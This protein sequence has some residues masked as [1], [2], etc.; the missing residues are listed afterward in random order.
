MQ[1]ITIRGIKLDVEKEIRKIAR[2]HGKS[3]NQV[4]KEIIHKEFN[5]KEAPAASLKDLAGGWT[6]EEAREFERSIEFCEQIDED[7]WK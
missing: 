6:Q 4:I 2:E 7:L 3:I 5:Q 1:Q